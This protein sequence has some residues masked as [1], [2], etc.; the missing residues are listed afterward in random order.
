MGRPPVCGAFQG[1]FASG[2]CL[3][4][5]QFANDPP[6]MLSGELRV[7]L[8]GFLSSRQ[9]VNEPACI[10]AFSSAFKTPFP[11]VQLTGA[12]PGYFTPNSTDSTA[13]RG[14][15]R[16]QPAADYEISGLKS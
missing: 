7:N 16:A 14:R 15:P 4:G 2:I 11:L 9:G 5:H 8:T 13:L 10:L 6:E 12:N 3:T 1:G